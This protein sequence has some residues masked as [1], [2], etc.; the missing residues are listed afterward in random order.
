MYLL[1]WY[2]RSQN[3]D[4]STS[5]GAGSG[6]TG[7]GHACWF[8][9]VQGEN[10][11]T[12]TP[13]S[14]VSHVRARNKARTWG[15]EL[16][17]LRSFVLCGVFA[18][19]V[20]CSRATEIERYCREVAVTFFAPRGTGKYPVRVRTLSLLPLSSAVTWTRRK[21]VSVLGLVE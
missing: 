18:F 5:L 7:F 17:A 19:R 13:S 1:R 15:T 3:Q 11:K 10:G 14:A 12:G 2:P 9:V 16:F 8:S 6:A 21:L 4:P 20:R